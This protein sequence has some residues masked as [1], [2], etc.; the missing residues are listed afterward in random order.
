MQRYDPAREVGALELPNPEG[1]PVTAP[2]PP[3][4]EKSCSNCPAFL[5]GGRQNVVLGASV[6]GPVCG[7]RLIAIGRPGQDTGKPVE[8]LTAEKCSQYGS[9]PDYDASARTKAISFQ[10]ALPVPQGTPRDQDSVNTCRSCA[11]YRP[12]HAVQAET[13]WTSGYCAANGTLLLED[14]LREYANGC[15]SRTYTS[16]PATR[17]SPGEIVLFPEFKDG[18]GK[19]SAAELLMG[20]GMDPQKF[21]TQRKVSTDAANMGVR[22]WRII[23]DP[24]GYGPDLVL[25]IFD[26]EFFADPEAR[27]A[28]PVIGDQEHPED[29]MDHSGFVYR[30]TALWMK[31]DEMPAL[32]G[33][34]GVGKTELFRHMAFLMALPFTRIS[35][36][37]S[38][39]V[40]DLVGKMGYSPEQGTY[41][42]FGRIPKMWSSPNVAVVDEANTAQPEVWMT[43]RPMMDNSSTLVL[44]QFDGRHIPRHRNCYVGFAMNPAWDPRNTG[45]NTLADADGSRLMHLYMDLPPEEVERQIIS[46]ALTHDRWDEDRIRKT[47]DLVMS[48]AGDIRRLSEDSVIPVT[49]GI[50]N[51]IKVARAMKFFHPVQAYRIGMADSLEPTAGAAILDVIK[52]KAEGY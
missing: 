34:S 48:C 27:A 36:T 19:R 37:P 6:G 16:T 31:L 8:K 52:S 29:Y 25:P 1:E 30:I 41:F 18:F 11:N 24:E 12:G 9:T 45:V 17:V 21:E 26:R 3:T 13:G 23:S 5:N 42:M 10:V 38:S 15:P 32:W 14:R 39:E 7:L 44:D 28:I 40:D 4:G 33:V 51:Q 35:I 22:A 50:R 43:L 2:T 46:K 47:V 49:W 20:R